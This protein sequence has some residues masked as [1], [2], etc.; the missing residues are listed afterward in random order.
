MNDDDDDGN[1]ESDKKKIP[2]V[3]VE[4]EKIFFCADVVTFDKDIF[5]INIVALADVQTFPHIPT[6]HDDVVCVLKV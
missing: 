4:D 6:H 2:A 5:F 3:L 1:H